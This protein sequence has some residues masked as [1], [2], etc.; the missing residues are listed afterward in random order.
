MPTNDYS[1][2]ARDP[3]VSFWLS[4]QSKK[5]SNFLLVIFTRVHVFLFFFFFF[6]FLFL[7]FSE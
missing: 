6:F 7:F 3:D 2:W 1:N 5:I 4:M